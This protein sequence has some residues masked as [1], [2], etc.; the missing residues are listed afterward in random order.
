MTNFIGEGNACADS[1]AKF[2]ATAT[3]AWWWNS[4]PPMIYV[5]SGG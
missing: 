1:L 5:R 2:G 4:S 3:E